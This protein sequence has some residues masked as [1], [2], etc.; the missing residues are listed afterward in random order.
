MTEMRV[1]AR[2]LLQQLN[3]TI[4]LR[5]F[6]STVVALAWVH[7]SISSCTRKLGS[8]AHARPCCLSNENSELFL[9]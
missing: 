8:S 4:F 2:A 6:A 5:S 7:E 9:P 3:F 1:L